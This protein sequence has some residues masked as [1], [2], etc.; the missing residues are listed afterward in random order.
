MKFGANALKPRRTRENCHTKGRGQRLTMGSY[1]QIEYIVQK[2]RLLNIPDF[3]KDEDEFLRWQADEH[4]RYLAIVTTAAIEQ[5]E[6]DRRDKERRREEMK[7]PAARARQQKEDEEN[8]EAEEMLLEQAFK[9]Y[10][11]Y[12]TGR[13]LI[14]IASYPIP[15]FR[16]YAPRSVY[17][18]LR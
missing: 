6:V 1:F 8:L 9:A 5:T 2:E 12:S 4:R 14:C 10:Q 13:P 11:P 3:P 7:D 16:E 17:A 18:C 15:G